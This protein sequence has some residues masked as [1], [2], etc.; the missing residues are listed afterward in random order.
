MGERLSSKH[1]TLG[2]AL[3]SRER[4]GRQ[5]G[6]EGEETETDEDRELAKKMCLLVEIEQGQRTA[7]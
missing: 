2:L 4:R 1:K 3:S 5:G 6:W 7:V